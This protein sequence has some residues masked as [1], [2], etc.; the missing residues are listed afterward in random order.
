MAIFPPSAVRRLALSIF[1]AGAVHAQTSSPVQADGLATPATSPAAVFNT[2]LNNGL[3]ETYKAI[4]TLLASIDDTSL[5]LPN[6]QDPFAVDAQAVCPGYLASNVVS[7]D[8]GFT[9]S[10]RLAGK[11]I[12]PCLPYDFRLSHFPSPASRTAPM[13]RP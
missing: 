4:P 2:V 13:S 10:L 9:A 6:I 11:V 3:L 5:V 1:S 12:A 8:Y 7:N